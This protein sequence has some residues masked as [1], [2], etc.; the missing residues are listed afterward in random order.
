MPKSLVIVESNAKTK[1]IN[2][3]LGKDYIVVSSIGHVKD[4]P[5]GKLGVDLVDS[6]EPNYI[7]IRGKGSVL[8][9]LKKAASNSDAVYLATD[10]D[11]EGEAIAWHIYEEIKPKV[12]KIHRIMFNE[13]T[14]NAVRKAIQN[15]L[16][17]DKNKVEAQKARRVLDR[18]VGYQVSPILWNTIY[19]GLSAGRVQSVALRLIV[20]REVEIEKFVPREYWTIT[21]ELKGANT[22]SFLSKLV[23]I[24]K[25]KPEI[26]NE[27]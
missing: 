20:E 11:R 23:K 15:P 21:A 16:T 8:N 5:K 12:N 25:E 6:Y 17:I 3:F 14:E 10:P 1:T 13:I 18:L 24:D 9:E 22:K 19:K 4:L 27:K 7:T 2:K 26:P